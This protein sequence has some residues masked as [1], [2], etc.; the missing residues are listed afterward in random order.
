MLVKLVGDVLKQGSH[1][2]QEI[3]RAVAFE[4]SAKI[5]FKK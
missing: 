5:E 3:V 2:T 1:D 4:S